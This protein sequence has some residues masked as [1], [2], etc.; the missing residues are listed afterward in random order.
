MHTHKNT[1]LEL[2]KLFASYMVVFIHVQFPG[3][4]GSAADA[5]ACFA[6]PLFFLISGYFSY[7]ITCQKIKLRI[8]HIVTLIILATLSYNFYNILPSLLC[9]NLNQIGLYFM[10]YFD[11]VRFIK[12]LVF[13][14]SISAVHLWYL[15]AITYVYVISYIVTVLRIPEKTIFTISFLLLFLHVLL[16]EVLSVFGIVLPILLLRNF[17]L[18]GIPFFYLGQFFRKHENK[19]RELPNYVF[20]IAITIGLIGTILSRYFFGKNEL[21]VGSLFILFAIVVFFIKYSDVTYPPILHSLAGCSTY[22][23]IFHFMVSSSIKKIYKLLCID[24]DSSILLG[25]GHPIIVCFVSTLL[26]YAAIKLI[27]KLSHNKN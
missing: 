12:L 27:N 23:Y 4:L 14:V 17:A 10:Q 5:T 2:I 7:Q 25:Y 16:G 11:T 20:I 13:N 26:A 1:T 22:I 3:K 21:C 15:L 6:V 18:M 19:L 9:G 8:K 24:L